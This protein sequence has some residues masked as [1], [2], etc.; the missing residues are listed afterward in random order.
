MEF[1]SIL[2]KNQIQIRIRNQPN[3]S[4]E[5]SA[6]PP[7][8][9]VPHLLPDTLDVHADDV[10]VVVVVQVGGAV[11]SAAAAPEEL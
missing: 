3:L 8:A 10:A 6:G 2:Q 5:P 11:K 9:P 1:W 7:L 4:D